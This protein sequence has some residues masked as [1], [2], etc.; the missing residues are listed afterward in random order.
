[1]IFCCLDFWFILNNL[2][3]LVIIIDII[4]VIKIDYVVI[5]IE[6]SISEKYVKGLGYWKMNCLFLDDEDYVRDVIIK[7][8]IWLIEG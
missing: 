7:I 1:M 5:F 8:F 6:F 3:D 2:Q 4:L